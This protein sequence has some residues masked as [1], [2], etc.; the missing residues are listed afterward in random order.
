M[1]DHLAGTLRS[2]AGVDPVASPGRG[3]G[4]LR[5]SPA[6]CWHL[7][8]AF[9]GE[10]P[11]GAVDDLAG[12]LHEV[13]DHAAPVDL[14]LRGAGLFAHRTLWVGAGGDLDGAHRLV[15]ACRTA[16]E[17]VGARPDRRVRSRLHLTLGRSSGPADRRGPG[18]R[19]R[20]RDDGGPGRGGRGPNP[21]GRGDVPPAP[22]PAEAVVHALA[23]YQGPAW[24]ARDLLLLRSEPGAGRAGGP[25]YT[26]VRRW[27]LAGGR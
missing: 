13:A 15:E 10:V 5:W 17:Q 21:P 27:P 3:A 12:A 24:T 18:R 6:E 1:L 19:Q 2:V 26:P 4:G 23:V 22:D 9:Y 7:T 16:G 8:L 14:H 11:D 20:R 25:L